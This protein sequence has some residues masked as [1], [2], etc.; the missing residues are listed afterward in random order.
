MIKLSLV[1]SRS[2]KETSGQDSMKDSLCVVWCGGYIGRGGG[3][4]KSRHLL[5]SVV[6]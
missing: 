1:F 3:G 2:F 4:G 5:Y 6:W